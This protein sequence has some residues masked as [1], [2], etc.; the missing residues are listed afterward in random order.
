MTICRLLEPFLTLFQVER[1]LAPFLYQELF[2]IMRN[3][4]STF[5]N[6]SIIS[7]I[8]NGSRLCTIDIDNV[9]NLKPS[10]KIEIG[11]G[12]KAK[13]KKMFLSDTLSFR[14]NTKKMLVAT[15]K[16]LE[17]Q[18]QEK[19]KMANAEARDMNAK[20]ASLKKLL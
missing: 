8:T 4:L 20:I 17:E 13:T 2:D 12:A 7:A 6:D 3:L 18:R 9:E 1:P 19:L 11:F 14:S 10:E 15:F 5:V 16:K